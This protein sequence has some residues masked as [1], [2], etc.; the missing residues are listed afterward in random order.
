MQDVTKTMYSIPTCWDQVGLSN[1]DRLLTGNT[2]V[3]IRKP[4]TVPMERLQ[5]FYSVSTSTVWPSILG[6]IWIYQGF[7]KLLS[8]SRESSMLSNNENHSHQYYLYWVIIAYYFIYGLNISVMDRLLK[9][10]WMGQKY[11]NI[12]AALLSTQG[13]AESYFLVLGKAWRKLQ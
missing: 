3:Y 6:T 1:Q 8:I 5:V 12:L 9:C 4:I 10:Q 11:I 7:Q 13:Y 2:S